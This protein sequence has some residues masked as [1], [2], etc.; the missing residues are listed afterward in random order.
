MDAEL[1][2]KA[3]GLLYALGGSGGGLTCYLDDG[4]LCYEHNPFILQRTKIRSEDRLRA[5]R[6]KIEISIK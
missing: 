5:G 6:T 2:E 3:S 4:Y 1:P